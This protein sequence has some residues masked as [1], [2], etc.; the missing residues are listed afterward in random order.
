MPYSSKI[1]YQIVND[2][3]AYPEFLPWCG[4][5]RVMSETDDSMEAAV[6]MKKGPL[7]HWFSTRNRLNPHSEIKM[8]LIDG[9]FKKLRGAWRFESLDSE[10]SKISLDLEFEFSSGLTS[11]LLTPIFSQIA[12]TMVDSFCARVQDLNEK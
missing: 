3:A 1:M 7:N 2:V 9:P 11:K 8:E 10:S 6:L 4:G 12:N 5:S